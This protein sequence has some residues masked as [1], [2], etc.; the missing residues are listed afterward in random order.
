MSISGECKHTTLQQIPMAL[1]W[2]CRPCGTAM[3]EPPRAAILTD[4]ADPDYWRQQR[5]EPPA[6][7]ERDPVPHITTRDP[8]PADAPREPSAVQSLARTADVAGWRV[9]VD[10]SRGPERAVRVGTYKLTETFGVWTTPHPDT[11]WRFSAIYARTVGR[12][13][14]SWTRIAIWRPGKLVGP[15]LGARFTHAT[16]TDLKAFVAARGSVNAAWFKA[17]EARAADK[18][19][20]EGQR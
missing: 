13:T 16:V 14:W 4:S 12:P 6:W 10:Y 15:G 7:P 3:A 18:T 19:K 1:P 17:I 9:R 11:G 2:L 8:R 5:P 20:R